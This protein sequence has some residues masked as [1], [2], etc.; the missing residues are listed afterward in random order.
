VD[1]RETRFGQK[2]E[3]IKQTINEA[4]ES[5]RQ[6]KRNAIKA[7]SNLGDKC[8]NVSNVLAKGRNRMLLR[9]GVAAADVEQLARITGVNKA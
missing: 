8:E 1:G 7:K 2:Y 9:G 5:R 6:A 3:A 4:K